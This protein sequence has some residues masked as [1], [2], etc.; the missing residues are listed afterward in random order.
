MT[1]QNPT[2]C[3]LRL[4]FNDCR[5]EWAELAS[6]DDIEVCATVLEATHKYQA[7]AA[8]AAQFGCTCSIETY[9]AL[10]QW[11]NVGRP[12]FK[13]YPE[14]L[15]ILLNTPLSMPVSALQF[16][17]GAFE[18]RLPVGQTA[19]VSSGD[20]PVRSLLCAT[21]RVNGGMNKG[22]NVI[23][24]LDTGETEPGSSHPAH[25]IMGFPM[26]SNDDLL[27]VYDVVAGIKDYLFYGKRVQNTIFSAAFT[28]LCGVSMIGTND[29]TLVSRDI[30]DGFARKLKHKDHKVRERVR[31]QMG[32]MHIKRGYNIGREIRLPSSQH[33]STED[34]ESR[35][36]DYQYGWLRRAHWAWR[37]MGH[38][39][40][41]QWRLRPVKVSRFLE[42]LPLK[43][44]PGF[45]LSGLPA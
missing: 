33:R 5:K 29:P 15:P 17:F 28:L 22:W 8:E 20:N 36:K 43:P 24:A 11:M 12:Y 1:N 42:E 37:L 39:E 18:V 10:L 13:V 14:M 30:P 4:P 44:S 34:G 3:S 23:V 25:T 21:Y 9:T 40:E 41:K 6:M 32:S 16:P 26:K 35:S 45:I 7:G 31:A 38:G 19:L 2:F 27:S